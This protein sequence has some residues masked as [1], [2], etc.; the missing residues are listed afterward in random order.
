MKKSNITSSYLTKFLAVSFVFVI[1][2]CVLMRLPFKNRAEYKE[3]FKETGSKAKVLVIDPGHGGEDGGASS[4]DGTYEKDL[5]LKLSLLCSKILKAGG[6]DVRLTRTDDRMTYDMYDDLDDY[7]GIKKTYDL[8]NRIRFAEEAAADIFVSIHMNKFFQKQYKGL[9][10]Y[11][12]P[13]DPSSGQYAESVQKIVR[14][15]LQEYNER[16]TKES[17]SSIY[18][19]TNITCPAILIECG[20]LSNNDDLKDLLNSSYDLDLAICITSALSNDLSRQ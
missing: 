12:S 17:T 13:N 8:R 1:T 16:K 11:Y 9:Q 2:A 15:N 5:N 18:I 20:F 7:T 14:N 3:V 10:V 4:D 6:Y 19:L